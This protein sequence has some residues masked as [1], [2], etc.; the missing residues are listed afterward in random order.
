MA[1]YV[2][3]YILLVLGLLFLVP[4]LLQYLWNITM[5]DLFNLK[6]ITYWQAFRLLLI[7]GMLFGGPFFLVAQH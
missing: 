7:A 6:Q 1:L 4:L 5:P 2:L 3:G